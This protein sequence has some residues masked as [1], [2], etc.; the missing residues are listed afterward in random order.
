[1]N[2]RNTLWA[3]VL[4]TGLGAST[5]AQAAS[6]I[7]LPRPG[8]VG[9]G[10]QGG[11]GML[12]E[13]G[14]LGTEFGSGPE[15]AVRLRYRMRFERGLGLSFESQRLDARAFYGG[16]GSFVALGDSTL[17]RDRLSLVTSGVE[18]YQMFDTRTRTTKMLS[19]GAGLAQLSSRL[20]DGETQYP[21]DGDGFYVSAG[22]GI[23]RFIYRSWALDLSVRY[24]TIFQG[25]STNHDLQ[26]AAGIMFYASY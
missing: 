20:T 12:L 2:V 10:I 24:Q 15:V 4:V 14:K 17:A 19:V 5:V 22:A 7:V 21:D 9:L 11:Y 13:S 3:V 23:E 18:F 1:M 16:S 25:G 6:S 8:Q 26:L